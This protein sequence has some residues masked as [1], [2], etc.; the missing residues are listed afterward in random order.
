MLENMSKGE[1]S[2]EGEVSR[3]GERAETPPP[4][5]GRR[6]AGPASAG[7]RSEGGGPRRAPRRGAGTL[8]RTL[9]QDGRRGPDRERLPEAGEAARAPSSL[10]HRNPATSLLVYEILLTKLS[11]N[12]RKKVTLMEAK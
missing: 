8:P 4:S 5:S 3:P 12:H 7:P 11:K 1:T 2:G 6:G 9:L 10:R